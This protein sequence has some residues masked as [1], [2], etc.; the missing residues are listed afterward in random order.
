MFFSF[1]YYFFPIFP[2][3]TS[4]LNSP[5]QSKANASTPSVPGQRFFELNLIVFRFFYEASLSI[6]ATPNRLT[7]NILNKS[8]VTYQS[9]QSL[10]LLNLLANSL[11]FLGIHE[12][13]N[14]IFYLNLMLK[15]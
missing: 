4:Q 14:L 15:I 3:G 5:A 8:G 6:V 13:S 12:I 2:R 1:S 7:V 10:V 11:L 9:S